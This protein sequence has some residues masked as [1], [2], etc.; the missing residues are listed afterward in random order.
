MTIERAHWPEPVPDRLQQLWLTLV[1]IAGAVPLLSWLD[2][3]IAVLV[4]ALF[5]LRLVAL[6]WHG[7]QPGR[8]LL[9][10]LTLAAVANC[11]YVY[12]NLSGRQGGAALFLSMLA[13][14]LL[15]LRAR[16]DLQ[17]V[18]I[19]LGF[20]VVVQFLFDQS[21]G[22]AL[23][24]ALVIGGM[25]ALLADLNGA[26]GGGRLRPA[27]T[28]TTRLAL[29]ALPLTLVLFLLFPRLSAPLWD[30]GLDA[31]QARTGFSDTME[32]GAVSE[33]V[34]NGELAFRVRFYAT[35]PPPEQRYW[36]G[37]V[38]WQTDGRRW[39]VGEPPQG[40]PVSLA[41]AAAADRLDYE[42]VLEPTDRRW[43]FALDLPVAAEGAAFAPDHLLRARRAVESALRYRVRSALDY[44]TSPP[45]AALRD[46][47]LRLP[48][49]TITPRMRALVASWRGEGA[50]D[51]AVVRR[52]LAH[53]NREAFHY[54]L[55]PPPLGPNPVD[56]FLFETRRGFCEHYASSFATL[57]RLA[58]I[59]SRVVLGYLGSEPNAIGGYHMVWQSDA[60]AWVEVLLPGRGWV[61][62]DPTAAV[63]PSRIDNQ[64]ASRLLGAGNPVRFELTQGAWLAQLARGARQFADSIDAAWQD[65][66]LDF[67]AE[68][69][70]GLL[71]RLGLG[72]LGEY[73][74]AVLM[75][76]TFSL[77][78]GAV[79]LGLVRAPRVSD[80]LVSRHARFCRR[81]ARI[82]LAPHP[83][84]GPQDHGR[85]VIAA[86]PDLAAPV[87][88]FLALY[89]P[90]RFGPAPDPRA[91]VRLDALLR[92]FRPRRR[93]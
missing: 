17:L 67:S 70:L 43:L 55:L 84:E 82:G 20:L 57:M 86:R 7:A 30:L 10:L 64:S 80:P 90:A 24:L 76:A 36:R 44:R 21:L 6:R 56:A 40:G 23:Y 18:A 78:L 2:W 27:L 38:L 87:S 53:F 66:V 26:A 74:L 52:A 49:A 13:L 25:L 61:R 91:V 92:G 11:L 39:T 19:L 34:V 32:P 73:G 1:V 68:D 45:S 72:R 15:E 47:A 60:H 4:V 85:R 63:D 62:V 41:L 65:W 88:R 81:L 48:A 9:V 42:V 3:R 37:L 59:P 33:L 22:L 71:Q 54:T 8:W 5:A 50:D 69:Q 75:V 51:Q 12:G 93:R 16:R 58:G 46:Y 83:G 31:E 28:T 14:K 79:L 29:Q 77:T 35:P 89:L